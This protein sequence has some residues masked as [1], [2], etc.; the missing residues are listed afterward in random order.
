M[1]SWKVLGGFLGNCVSGCD[2]MCAESGRVPSSG[3]GLIILLQMQLLL[4]SSVWYWPLQLLEAC[5]NTLRALLTLYQ[6]FT[7]EGFRSDFWTSHVCDPFRPSLQGN[8]SYY[9]EQSQILCGGKTSHHKDRGLVPFF[10][11]F[12]FS[13]G[14]QYVLGFPLLLPQCY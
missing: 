9:I 8:V 7:W 14:P 13:A 4:R 2:G 6:G 1:W 12:F 5:D 10:F 11:C 3:P